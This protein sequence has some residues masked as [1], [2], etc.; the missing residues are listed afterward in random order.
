MFLHVDNVME[1]EAQVLPKK[2][3]S[4]ET[5]ETSI[6]EQGETTLGGTTNHSRT[7]CEMSKKKDFIVKHTSNCVSQ[8]LLFVTFRFHVTTEDADRERSQR[9]DD[10]CVW[11][12]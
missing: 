8:V 3:Q 4:P 9:A 10:A 12:T 5:Q 6:T 7:K 1:E 2:G 11:T